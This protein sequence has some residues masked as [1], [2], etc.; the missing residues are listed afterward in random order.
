MK[1]LKYFESDD[2]EKLLNSLKDLSHNLDRLR[3]Y[4]QHQNRQRLVN[5]DKQD[6]ISNEFQD[7]FQELLDDG[8][9]FHGDW[10][11]KFYY[12]SKLKK[13]IKI[14]VIESEFENI[15]DRMSEVRDRLEDEGFQ[16]KFIIRFN[17]KHQQ[18]QNPDSYRVPLYQFTGIGDSVSDKYIR[19]NGYDPSKYLFDGIEY[20]IV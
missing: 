11:P 16:S 7:Y 8:W 14:D 13:F 10:D 17:G 20:V 3:S 15:V 5:K 19:R 6:Y 12:H 9:K 2:N 1:H 18:V 4:A